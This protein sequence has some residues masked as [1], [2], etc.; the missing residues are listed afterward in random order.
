[1]GRQNE[2]FQSSHQKFKA[3][4]LSP[5]MLLH[6]AND[7]Q[8]ETGDTARE[9][10][11]EEKWTLSRLVSGKASELFMVRHR[12]QRSAYKHLMQLSI[13]ASDGLTP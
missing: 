9:Y 2:L 3:V 8:F 5:K 11:L 12:P 6:F 1:M 7:W 4:N 10:V 13:K